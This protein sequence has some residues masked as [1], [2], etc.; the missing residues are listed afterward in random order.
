VIEQDVRDALAAQG[1]PDAQVRTSLSPPWSTDWI[2]E[3]GRE[4]LRAYGIA[5]PGPVSREHV[6]VR[7][8][9]SPARKPAPGPLRAARRSGWN[10]CQQVR[11]PARRCIGAWPAANP[12]TTS[13]RTEPFTG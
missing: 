10:A 9:G 4:K 7:L 6:P 11:L 13:S 8:T 3:Q 2:S 5:P 12:S 1:W